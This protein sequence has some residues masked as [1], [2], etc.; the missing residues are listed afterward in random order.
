M[1][2]LWLQKF[3]VF[4]HV[5]AHM[6]SHHHIYVNERNPTQMQHLVFSCKFKC[7]FCEQSFPSAAQ[8]GE[9]T[10]SIHVRFAMIFDNETAIIRPRST[11][12]RFPKFVEKTFNLNIGN[13]FSKITLIYERRCKE[14]N[15]SVSIKNKNKIID[16]KYLVHLK[17]KWQY[18]KIS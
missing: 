16:S 4:K 18:A 10:K 11:H 2:H 14:S 7:P 13:T 15:F 3:A 5:I 12:G 17:N 6:G 8:L 9:H 1:Q